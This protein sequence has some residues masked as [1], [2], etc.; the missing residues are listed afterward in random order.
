MERA[1]SIDV[2]MFSRNFSAKTLDE[3]TMIAEN[4]EI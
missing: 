1:K 2:F 4:A 3:I